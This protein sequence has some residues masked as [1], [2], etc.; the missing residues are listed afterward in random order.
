M[1]RHDADAIHL[2]KHSGRLPRGVI[3]G[4]SNARGALLSYQADVADA[5]GGDMYPGVVEALIQENGIDFIV[6]AGGGMLG[7][8]MGYKAGAMAWRQAIDAVLAG[9]SLQEAAQKYPEFR[10][11][12]ELW[13]G[14]RADGEPSP[15]FSIAEPN[16]MVLPLASSVWGSPPLKPSIRSVAC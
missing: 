6:P 2:V 1:L 3:A 4:E 9:M 5:G 14:L 8:P 13:G 12:A 10:A 11:A 7:H 15:V 16:S